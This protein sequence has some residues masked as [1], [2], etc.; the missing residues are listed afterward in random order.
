MSVASFVGGVALTIAAAVPS[1]SPTPAGV[2]LEQ[3]AT[4][5]LLGFVVTFAIALA[6]IGLFLSLTRHLRI[7]DRRARQRAEE[8]SAAHDVPTGEPTVPG[9]A[10]HASQDEPHASQDEPQAP[11]DQ[12]S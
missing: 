3:R 9:D 10:P 5:G 11:G 8:D 4:P 7:V 1:P 6:A 12:S 2:P